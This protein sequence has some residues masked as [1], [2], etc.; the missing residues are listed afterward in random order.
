MLCAVRTIFVSE[1]HVFSRPFL[2]HINRHSTKDCYIHVSR[3]ETIVNSAV[4]NITLYDVPL[5]SKKRKMRKMYQLDDQL[6][7]C[8]YLFVA[9]SSD[10]NIS[11]P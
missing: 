10:C 3:E 9:L 11:Y 7:E 2:F 1:S 8:L 5:S 4:R 6:F